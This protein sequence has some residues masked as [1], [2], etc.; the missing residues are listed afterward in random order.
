MIEAKWYYSEKKVWNSGEYQNLKRNTDGS[1]SLKRENE[2]GIFVTGLYYNELNVHTWNRFVID[3]GE[4]TA[5]RTYVKIF[6]N[7]GELACFQRCQG[8]YAK[9]EYLKENANIVSDFKDILLY[10]KDIRGRYLAACIC[11]FP[12]LR[13]EETVL[14]GFRLSYPKMNFIEYLPGIYLENPFLERYLAVFETLYMMNE[15]AIDRMPLQLWLRYTDGEG[16]ARIA[17]MLGA[18]IKSMRKCMKEDNIRKLLGEWISLNKNRGTVQYYKRIIYLM[19]EAQVIITDSDR[20]KTK[21]TDSVCD[22]GELFYVFYFGNIKY[23]PYIREFL[24]REK[25]LFTKYN[26]IDEETDNG[27]DRECYLGLNTILL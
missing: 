20:R 19:S 18:D 14:R 10:E 3:A 21:D 17:G 1:M 5:V 13:K 16:L 9:A 6:D 7:H 25:P 26:L 23:S 15:T 24:D 2:T 27:L 8:V 12:V 4:N 22:R 11:I